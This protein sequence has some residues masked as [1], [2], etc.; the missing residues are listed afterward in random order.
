MVF[1]RAGAHYGESPFP[2]TPYQKAGQVWDERIGS[3]RVQARNWRLMALGLL[4]ALVATSGAL[5]WRSLQSAVTPY[6]VEVD[7]SGAV[8]SVAPALG[9]YDP[10]DAQVAHQVAGFIRNV[11][12]LSV[13]PVVVRQNWLQ[14]YEM[15][16]DRAAAT[17]SDYARDNDPFADIGRRSRAV[18]V[19]SVV[20][21]TETS[22]QARWLEK[23]YENGALT[24]ARRFTGHFTLVRQTPRDAATLQA[25]PL[26]LYIHSLNWGEDLVTGDRP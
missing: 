1:R 17:L 13:D 7:A 3:A 21:V 25:N 2:E 26:G 24:G 16:T 4:A 9:S 20:R 14:A 6:V 12:S 11:R 19:I 18:E 8:R 15:V 10:S 22:F 5:V 23:T